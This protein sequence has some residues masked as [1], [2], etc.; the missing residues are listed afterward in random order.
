MALTGINQLWVADITYIRLGMEFV[1]LAVVIDAFSRRVIGW[2]LE[3]T[4]E[5]ELT[6]KD[7][8]HPERTLRGHDLAS[9][10]RPLR[11]PLDWDERWYHSQSG[12]GFSS[13]TDI[14]AYAGKVAG[15]I[16]EGNEGIVW[17]GVMGGGLVRLTDGAM[18]K[19]T[20]QQGLSSDVVLPIYETHDGVEQF[21][22][23]I[24]CYHDVRC[25]RGLCPARARG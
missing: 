22:M 16:F 25:H 20:S 4:V 5:D 9:S 24:R 10:R 2:A 8:D 11:E 6:P 15:G 17:F 19:C 13:I 23:A 1:Y 21:H 14:S 3:R 12:R 18:T 7:M